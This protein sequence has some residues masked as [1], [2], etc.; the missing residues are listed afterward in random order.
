MEFKFTKTVYKPLNIN[1]MQAKKTFK[2]GEYA[3]GGIITVQITGKIVQ[4]KALDWF[5]KKVVSSGSTTIDNWS[6]ISNYLNDLTSSYYADTIMN[7]IRLKT[8][9]VRPKQAILNL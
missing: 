8:N 2:I 4:I 3:I 6:Q 5:T 1:V 9:T 7:W